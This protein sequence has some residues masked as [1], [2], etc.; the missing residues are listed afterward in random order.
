MMIPSCT[1]LRSVNLI[2]GLLLSEIGLEVTESTGD[3]SV[4]FVVMLRLGEEG[5]IISLYL[6]AQ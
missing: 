5:G 2:L 6:I 1:L 3:S 4:I